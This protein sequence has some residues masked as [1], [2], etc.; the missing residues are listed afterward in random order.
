MDGINPPAVLSLLISFVMI[1]VLIVVIQNGADNDANSH[2][3]NETERE[4]IEQHPDEQPQDDAQ[5]KSHTEKLAR[6]F[7]WMWC[8]RLHSESPLVVGQ[9]FLLIYCSTGQGCCHR[10]QV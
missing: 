7:A 1:V 4:H 6:C 10:S 3:Y 9:Y 8:V 2:P 5:G